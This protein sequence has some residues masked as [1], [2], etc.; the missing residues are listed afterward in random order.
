[1][2]F[3]PH[4]HPGE[5]PPRPLSSPRPSSSSGVRTAA[6]QARELIHL[7]TAFVRVLYVP[8]SVE[9]GRPR[10]CGAISPVIRLRTAS[11][12]AVS[13]NQLIP[14]R[15]PSVE[16]GDVEQAGLSHYRISCRV[17]AIK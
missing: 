2:A 1:M 5:T 8:H 7:E 16:I 17:I 4:D 3:R 9:H 12:T 15:S 13:S 10:G 6:V 14:L 11:P